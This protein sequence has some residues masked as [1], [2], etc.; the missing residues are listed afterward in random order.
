MDGVWSSWESWNSCTVSCGGGIKERTRICMYIRD[1]P[2]GKDCGEDSH[3]NKTCG[4]AECPG[5]FFIY[6]F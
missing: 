5:E 3:E 2:Q 6:F 4:V 1:A